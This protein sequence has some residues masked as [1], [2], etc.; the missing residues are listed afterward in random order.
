MLRLPSQRF[1]HTELHRRIATAMYVS[2]RPVPALHFY[3]N[4][5]VGE[6]DDQ[7]AVRQDV[8]FA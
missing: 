1:D 6:F 4:Q 8:L 5:W 7:N 3:T 2:A